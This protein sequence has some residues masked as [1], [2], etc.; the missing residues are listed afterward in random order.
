MV[1]ARVFHI[2][3]LLLILA[4][5]LLTG[6]AYS[7]NTNRVDP[8]PCPAPDTT[9]VLKL[10]GE[11]G[12]GDGQYMPRS[13]ASGKRTRLLHRR[14]ELE[15]RFKLSSRVNTIQVCYSNDDSS[16]RRDTIK[17][18]I[19]NRYIGKFVT[20]DTGN[21]GQGWNIFTYKEF[22]PVPVRR[23]W[24]TLRMLVV[25]ADFHGVEIDKIEFR[26]R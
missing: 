16:L 12:T 14:D 11:N 7:E 18:W 8:P 5:I 23:G 22:Y 3:G 24:H 13:N 9:T 25:S 19:D 26:K 15:F 17:L 2:L 4:S 20:E 6:T 21:F 10:E 1:S